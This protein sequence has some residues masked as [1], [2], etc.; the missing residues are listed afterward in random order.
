MYWIWYILIGM[1]AG[2]LGS[3]IIKG[4]GMGLLRNLLVGII[5]SVLGGW[6][7][8]LMGLSA[9]G[10]IGSLI[11]AVVG[12]VILLWIVSLFNKPKKE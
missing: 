8:G 9:H 7:F 1:L 5:G 10:K 4:H 6:V 12:A 3:L 11:T 2:Y